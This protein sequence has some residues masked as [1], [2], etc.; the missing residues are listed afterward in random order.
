MAENVPEDKI[1]T[2]D[3]AGQTLDAV[4]HGDEEVLTDDKTRHVKAS[5]PNDLASLYPDIQNQWDADEW[6]WSS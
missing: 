4:E 1:S 2:G 6:P 3:V 5:L